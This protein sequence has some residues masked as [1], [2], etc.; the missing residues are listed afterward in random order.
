MCE[1]EL[2]AHSEAL[3]STCLLPGRK[4]KNVPVWPDKE[5]IFMYAACVFVSAGLYSQK[6]RE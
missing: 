2:I 5:C 1:L 6:K 4:S 3:V